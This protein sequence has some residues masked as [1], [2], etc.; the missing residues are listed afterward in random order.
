MSEILQNSR[1]IFGWFDPRNRKLGSMGLYSESNNRVWGSHFICF[2][3][4]HVWSISKG[5]RCL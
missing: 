5:T 3:F 1:K 4:D 2:S